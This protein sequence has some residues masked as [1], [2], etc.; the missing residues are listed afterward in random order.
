VAAFGRRPSSPLAG[1]AG[2]PRLQSPDYWGLDLLIFAT[3]LKPPETSLSP[4]GVKSSIAR[5][6][7]VFFGAFFVSAVLFMMLLHG[8]F[9]LSRTEARPDRRACRA[10]I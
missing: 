5:S 8:L 4:A 7:R 1:A 9:V 6:L 10:L 2:S 3:K